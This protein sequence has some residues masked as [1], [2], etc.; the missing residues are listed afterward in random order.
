MKRISVGSTVLGF[1]MAVC[2]VS[3][4]AQQAP[5]QAALDETVKVY[6]AAWSEPDVDRRQ[7]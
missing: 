5:S 6:C 2:A 3:P 4:L 7:P 1:W